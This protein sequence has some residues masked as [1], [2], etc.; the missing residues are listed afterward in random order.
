M[1][2]GATS[3]MPVTTVL[4]NGYDL[5][6]WVMRKNCFPSFWGRSIT[7]ENK[8]TVDEVEYLRKNKCRVMLVFDELSEIEIATKSAVNQAQKAIKAAYSFGAPDEGRIAI[9]A[10]I[11]P[12]W[13][14]NHNWML[15]YSAQILK[16]GYIPGFIGN[17]DSSQNFSFDREIGHFL[18]FAN[19]NNIPAPVVCATEPKQLYPSDWLPFCPSDMSREDISFWETGE[20]NCG[21]VQAKT[22]W[23]RDKFVLANTW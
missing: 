22:M 9:F 6:S 5:F 10:N 23:A 21:D 2:F 18:R 7:G 15:S 16:S 13:C 1:I 8:L 12:N 14:V 19:N 17:T 3:K 11:S 4:S 20:E